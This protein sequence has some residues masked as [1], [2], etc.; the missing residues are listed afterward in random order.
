MNIVIVGQGA[1]GLLWYSQ[2][3]QQK[4]HNISLLCSKNIK[5]IPTE[6]LITDFKD[7]K[8]HIP[9]VATTD[10]MLSQADVIILCLKAFDQ[11]KALSNIFPKASPNAAFVMAHN[12]M[13]DIEKIDEKIRTKHPLLTLLTTHGC[14]KVKPFEVRHTGLGHSDLGLTAPNLL[15]KHIVCTTEQQTTIVNLLAS[16]LPTLS[17]N[18]NIAEKQWLKLAV[19]C[20]INPIT[21]IKNIDNGEVLSEIYS[22]KINAILDEIVAVAQFEDI[23]FERELLKNQVLR[24]AELTAKNSSSMRCDLLNKKTSEIDHINGYIVDLG[25]KHD[26]AT[27]VNAQLWQQIKHAEIW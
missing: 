18:K 3:A 7:K 20:V 5:N 2:L 23:Y 11:I 19:N 14:K 26:I 27:T 8:H 1:I 4:M 6:M 15:K 25:K 9:L 21:A 22:D 12:G 17:W 13:I 10:K 24:V 16:A